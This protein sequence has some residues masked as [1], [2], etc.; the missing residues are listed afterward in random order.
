MGSVYLRVTLNHYYTL[1]DSVYLRVMFNLFY[2]L[3]GSVYLRIIFN[4]L[5]TAVALDDI[6]KRGFAYNNLK[7]TNVVLE[8]REA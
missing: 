7:Y 1:L 4:P 6:R 8:K 2:T 5:Y 3:L